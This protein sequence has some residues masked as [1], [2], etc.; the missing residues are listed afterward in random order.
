MKLDPETI[1]KLAKLTLETKPED[2]S[3][4]DWVHRVGEYVEA[5]RAGREID[6]RLR[7]VAEH[8]THCKSCKEELQVLET[9]DEG[10]G[11]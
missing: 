7:V 8:A 10:G 9:L 4:D 11:D 1:K 5:R 3:C 2:I 6:A